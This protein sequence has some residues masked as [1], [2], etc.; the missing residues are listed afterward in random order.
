MFTQC[1]ACHTVYR[2]R[3]DQLRAAR[4]QVRCSRCDT[5][6]D[7]LDHRVSQHAPPPAPA[8]QSPQ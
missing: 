3:L 7:A 2:L 5:I 6:F 8:Q 4:G 1:P